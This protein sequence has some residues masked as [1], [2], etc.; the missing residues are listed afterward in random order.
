MEDNSQTPNFQYSE[1]SEGSQ[2]HYA[3][4]I[5]MFWT[6]VDVTLVFGKLLH[7]SEDISQNILSVENRF[8]I[9]FPW[10]VAKLIAGSLAQSVAKYE[11]RNGEV[12]LPG[13]YKLP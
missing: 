2:E 3:N 12:K 4:H 7:S 8:K 10:S 11:Q 13:E 6:G 5:Q 1:P 9:T